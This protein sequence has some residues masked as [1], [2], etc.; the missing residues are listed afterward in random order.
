MISLQEI[1]TF[2]CKIKVVTNLQPHHTLYGAPL[3]FFSTYRTTEAD[4]YFGHCS[5]PTP[6]HGDG[7]RKKRMENHTGAKRTENKWR[8]YYFDDRDTIKI[9][10]VQDGDKYAV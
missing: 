8:N 10:A 6:G 3:W 2:D 7:E 1:N 9:M 5:S 4:P